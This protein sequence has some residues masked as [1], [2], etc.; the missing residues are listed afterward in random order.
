MANQPTKQN[1]DEDPDLSLAG[2]RA[3]MGLAGGRSMQ[4]RS[5]LVIAYIY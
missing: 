1:D 2:G 3:S 5:P 4:P